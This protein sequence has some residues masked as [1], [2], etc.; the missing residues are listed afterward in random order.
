MKKTALLL[1][2]CLALVVS[3]ISSSAIINESETVDSSELQPST[4]VIPEDVNGDG[5]FNMFDY[6]YV[7]SVYFNIDSATDEEKAN[8]D[9]NGDGDV[10]MFDYATLKASYFKNDNEPDV[11]YG[12]VSFDAHCLSGIIG[13]HSNASDFK[14]GKQ[15]NTTLI[16]NSEQLNALLDAYVEYSGPIYYKAFERF[17]K[18]LEDDYFTTKALVVVPVAS[19]DGGTR[20][21]IK[22]VKLDEDGIL[23]EI[24]SEFY[25]PAPDE[26][27]FLVLTAEINKSDIGDCTVARAEIV[28]C[29]ISGNQYTFEGKLPFSEDDVLPSCLITD[30]ST[31]NEI[32]DSCDPI[33][34]TDF[35]EYAKSLPENFFE[36]KAI[37]VTS[38]TLPNSGYTVETLAIIGGKE[39]VEIYLFEWQKTG[40]YPDV[41]TYAVVVNEISKS[42]FGDG[43]NCTAYYLD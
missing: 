16:T 38:V 35:I 14:Y 1:A 25:G 29:N 27:Q 24:S 6:I 32:I 22:N 4:E 13:G 36:K 33:Y 15:I 43:T 39:G 41:V 19:R 9:L 31:L 37:T 40:E 26:P 2:I 18:A 10:N 34:G 11:N 23:M 3:S 12:D 7:K 8:A 5:K 17:A 42:D 30:A 20:F 21:N 28:R